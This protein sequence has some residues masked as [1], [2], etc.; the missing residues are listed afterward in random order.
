MDPGQSRTDLQ[1]YFSGLTEQTFETQLGVADPTLIDYI[2]D[3]LTRFVRCD[4]ILGPKSPL[5]RRLG[6]VTDMLLEAE[7][8]QGEA[9]RLV[10]R[11]IGD[12][13][14]FWTGVF[15][16]ALGRMQ[17][18][19]KPDS[20][21]DYAALGKRAYYIASMLGKDENAAESEV[22]ER[23]ST[24]YDLCQYGLR[25]LRREWERRDDEPIKPFFF[26]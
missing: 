19:D 9:R 12:Y 4:A 16:E 13:T 25:E 1:R 24:Q 10:H 26:N 21:F 17:A 14:L 20:F 3:L 22:L 5:G 2:A 18:P 15:P 6:G 23:L 11:H 7:T 8:R